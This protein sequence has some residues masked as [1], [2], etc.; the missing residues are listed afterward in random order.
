MK[1]TNF[2]IIFLILKRK[3]NNIDNQNFFIIISFSDIIDLFKILPKH[4]TR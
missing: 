4:Y 3:T 2:L 1:E